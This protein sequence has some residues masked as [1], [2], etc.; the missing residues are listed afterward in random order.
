MADPILR[1]ALAAI[2]GE[3]RATTLIGPGDIYLTAAMEQAAITVFRSAR[4]E[5]DHTRVLR[6]ALNLAAAGQLTDSSF[7][8]ERLGNSP[9][10]IAAERN[11]DAMSGE[12]R[13]RDR[14]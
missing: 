13:R 12:R 8:I 2:L 10:M 4:P 9:A 6:Q 1:A 5:D 14:G 3:E 7:E 11:I